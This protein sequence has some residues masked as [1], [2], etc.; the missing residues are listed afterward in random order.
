MKITSRILGRNI[1]GVLVLSFVFLGKIEAQILP[2]DFNC[3]RG[4]TLFWDLPTNNCGPF[5]SYEIWASQSPTGPFAL[6]GT[7]TTQSQNFYAFINPSGQQWYFYLLSN[8]NCPGQTAIPSDTLDNRPPLISPIQTVSV[9]GGVAVV[10]WQPS[11]SPEVSGYIIYRETNIGVIPI[12]TVFGSNTFIDLASMPGAGPESYF[13]NAMDACGNTSIFDAKHTSIFLEAAPLPCRQSIQL[14]WNLYEGWTNGIAEQQIWS[15]IN[16]ATLAQ[17]AGAGTSSGSFEVKNVMDGATY[18]FEIRAVEAVTGAIVK[19]NQV[20]LQADIIQSAAGMFLANVSVTG[21]GEVQLTWD[22]N[23]QAELVEFEVLR[24]NQNT[25]YQ[26]IVSQSVTPPL[27]ASNTYNDAGSNANS[28]KV[29]YK[30]QTLDLCDSVLT[31]NYGSTIY[32]TAQ[33]LPGNI[34]QLNWTAFDIENASVSSYSIFKIVGGFTSEITTVGG[35]STS[36]Q[37][38]YDPNN[39]DEAQAC[40]YVV[41]NS[42]IVTQNGQSIDQKSRSNTACVKQAARIFAP[43]AFVPEGFNQEFKPLIV[44][45]DLANYEMLIFDRYGQQVFA[46]NDPDTGWVGQQNGKNLPQGLYAY[47]ITVT[48]SN[49]RVTEK[50]GTVLL[51]R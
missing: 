37:D 17:T 21:G 9:E 25:G 3:V 23:P 16:G 49:G 44:L 51:I 5:V 36:Y 1:L 41:A 7:V 6:Q 19:S 28:E 48:Q 27:S 42:K 45:G 18:C 35:G 30:I 33:P 24:S 29:F 39:V 46:T 12:D 11:P 43:N 32:L 40:Y 4:D 38:S 2:P 10:T 26:S 15:G 31:T 13:V 20:C 34:N 50:R 14:T 47:I 8:Y 22:W